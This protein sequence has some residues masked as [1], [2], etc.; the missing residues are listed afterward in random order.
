MGSVAT[1]GIKWEK[2]WRK[3]YTFSAGF[4]WGLF[5]P[6]MFMANKPVKF[7]ANICN[8]K[9]VIP[10]TLAL[11]IP[12]TSLQVGCFVNSRLHL[13]GGLIYFCAAEFNVNY[14]LS[15]K[16]SLNGKCCL[17]LDKIFKNRGIHLGFATI[18]IDYRLYT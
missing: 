17:L 6:D 10:Y 1:I 9:V 5:L 15:S 3:R 7:R 11:L 16:L 8:I 2:V 13:S 4:L 12:M 18:G 14:M